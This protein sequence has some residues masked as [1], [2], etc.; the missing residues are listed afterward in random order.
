MPSIVFNTNRNNLDIVARGKYLPTL[1]EFF[2]IL[3]TFSLTVFAW[4]FFRAAN[5]THA[6]SYI[7]EIFSKSIFTIPS[8][9][10]GKMALIISLILIL[11]IIIE[12][13]GREH[14]YAIAHLGNNWP[15]AIRWSLYLG[16]VSTLFLFTG[17]EQIFI[18][19]QF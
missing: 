19:F 15:R 3:L 14:Q 13:L 10:G 18:Y 1:R 6:F 17:K 16:I 12:W 5:V 7:S 2:A 8:F 9:G 11:F 4:I